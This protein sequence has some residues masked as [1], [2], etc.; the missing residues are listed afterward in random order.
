MKQFRYIINVAIFLLCATF[1]YAQCQSAYNRALR[2]YQSGNFAE[3]LQSFQWC[4]SYCREDVDLNNIDQYIQLCEKKLNAE[5]KAQIAKRKQIQEF[6]EQSRRQIE[7]NKLIFLSCEAALID[8]TYPRF[9]SQISAELAKKGYKFT[10]DKDKAYWII[11]IA[12]NTRKKEN[13]ENKDYYFFDCDIVGS[14]YN[15][16]S[17]MD[18]PFFYSEGADAVPQNNGTFN[19]Y[20]IEIAYKRSII[21]CVEEIEN[22]LKIQ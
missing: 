5:R 12:A 18:L 13:T 19:D 14:V 10:K 2:N 4:Q 22:I 17:D 16:I 8:K 20:A 15:T 3:A 7:K 1:G 6:Q 11:T 9:G 21:P